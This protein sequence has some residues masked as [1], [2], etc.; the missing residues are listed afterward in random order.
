LAATPRSPG[1]K[2]DDGFT[3]DSLL[4]FI[5]GQRRAVAQVRQ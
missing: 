3:Q 1:P 5:I 2:P 4:D